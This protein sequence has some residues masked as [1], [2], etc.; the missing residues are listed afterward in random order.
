[1]SA[2]QAFN[3]EFPLMWDPKALM[4]LQAPPTPCPRIMPWILL[5]ENHAMNNNYYVTLCI[6]GVSWSLPLIP[7]ESPVYLSYK[8]LEW[9]SISYKLHNNN[10]TGTEVGVETFHFLLIPYQRSYSLASETRIIIVAENHEL[11]NSV[12]DKAFAF[13]LT[14]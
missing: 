14:H 3:T 1:M 7:I 11:L 2:Q 6:G 4:W 12:V 8:S 13:G 9:S 5:G 10:V